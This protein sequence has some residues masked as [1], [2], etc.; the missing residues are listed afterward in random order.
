ML[1]IYGSKMCPDCVICKANLDYYHIEYEFLD[2]NENLKTLKD[3]L[4]YRDTYP[5][6]DHL[7]EVHDIGLPALVDNETVFTDWENY[8]KEKGFEPIQTNQGSSCSLN[9][10]GC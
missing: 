8:L 3:F 6:F 10:K 4:V 2:I 1:K 5:V 7:K 9:G